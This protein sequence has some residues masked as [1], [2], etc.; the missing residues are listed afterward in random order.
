MDANS[1]INRTDPSRI[2]VEQILEKS[3]YC[4]RIM[5]KA[6]DLKEKIERTRDEKTLLK[7]NDELQLKMQRMSKLKEYTFDLLD[8]FRTVPLRSKRLQQAEAY[9]YEGKYAEMD[10]VLDADKICEE[11]GRLSDEFALA[12]D[13][14]GM[15]KAKML[16]EERSYELVVKALYH[17]TFIENPKWYKDVYR[18]LSNAK[19]AS[20][21]VHTCFEL[22]SYLMKT[23]EQDWAFELLDDACIIAGDTEG[24]SYRLCEA[25][26]L[27]AL[28]LLSKQKADFPKAI[29]YAGKSL[30]IYTALSEKNPAEYRPR[31]SDM[32]VVMGNY[33]VG[34]RNFPVA[35]VEFEEAM[36]IRREL[37]LHGTQEDAM[38]LA[39]VLD[40]LGSVHLC[41]KEF[42]EAFARY[43]EAVRIKDDNVDFNL[44]HVLESK[45]NTLHNMESAYFTL[46]EYEKA[47]RLAKEELDI[48]KQVQE[49]D[50]FGQ[51][52]HLAE[53]RDM[54]G[55]LYLRLG[56][57]EDA[58][59]EREKALKIY[60]VLAEHAPE[61]WLCNLGEA[62]NHCSNLY[63]HLKSY[64]K[65]FLSMKE[66]IEIFRRLAVTDPDEYLTAVGCLL[67]N[68]CH[69]YEKI[70]PNREKA[71]EAAR[72][73][74]R[75]LSAVER[76]GDVE[77]AYDAAKQIISKY[78]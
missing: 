45:A 17:Y 36:K 61:N 71:L 11:T 23:N 46:H 8:T 54:L 62:T 67:S 34:S 49:T 18:L 2:V 47:I 66:A 33:S 9:F 32:L 56:Q 76:E 77:M 50:P 3:G 10:E 55:D 22:G 25:K 53:A 42:P 19:E 31:M 48:R 37:A 28:G 5:E 74:F 70:S 16:L 64:G 14:E 1:S 60:K 78:E 39:D 73:S 51:L 72:E 12:T 58:V 30:K 6:I 21:N 52:P 75:I 26:C 68:L 65:Y 20:F 69:Y 35:L 13:S 43:E 57:T 40:K 44:Y 4:N 15:E 24:E 27:W 63:F 7:L 38:H 41:L 59:R 29:E